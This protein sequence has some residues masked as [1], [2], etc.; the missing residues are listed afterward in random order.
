MKT[1]R[2]FTFFILFMLFAAFPA[3]ATG[4]GN[5][6]ILDLITKACQ[7]LSQGDYDKSISACDDALKIDPNCV[8]AY[9]TRGFACRYKEE[10]DRAIL[11]FTKAVTID[12]KYAQAYEQ[13]GIAYAY[14]GEDDKAISDFDKT[15]ELKP[16]LAEAY[17]NRARIFYN[18][19]EF[20]KAWENLHTAEEL[21]LSKDMIYKGFLK[22]LREASGRYN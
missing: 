15:I 22:K 16:T 3:P 20:G 21:G 13:R 9:Y 6:K 5:Q 17:F 4:A 11:D 2:L 8:A 7:Y 1:N 14:K 10:Y 12:S 18:K 19:E